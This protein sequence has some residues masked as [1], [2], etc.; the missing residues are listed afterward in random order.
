MGP[1][2]LVTTSFFPHAI[3]GAAALLYAVLLA[4]VALGLIFAG[5]SVI[6]GLAFLAVGLAGAAFGA[7]A[8]TIVLPLIGT[9][10]GGVV[11]FVVGGLI[12]LL[13]V[14]IGIGLA[15]GYFG[16]LTTRFLTHSLVLGVAI[17][18]ALFIVGVAISSKL[19]ELVTAILGGFILYGVLI[20]FGAAPFTAGVV[21]LVLAAVGF[22]VQETSRRREEPWRH[23]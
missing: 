5:R 23:G 22:V 21:S 2:E 12:G 10:V 16:Y 11:G 14:H 18:I 20:F 9:I 7:A 1:N 13:L 17:G 8:G 3:S 19:M 15:L 6:K 4:L